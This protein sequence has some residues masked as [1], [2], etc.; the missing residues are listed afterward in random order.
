M[1]LP[2]IIYSDKIIKYTSLS[3]KTAGK[4]IYP[5][6][7]LKERYKTDPIYILRAPKVI[8]HETIHFHQHQDLIIPFLMAILYGIDYIFKLFTNNF[9]PYI[10]YHENAFEREA[11]ENQYDTEY[12]KTR[13][14]FSWFKY[15]LR[16]LK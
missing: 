3:K 9:D 4:S 5:F 10:A 15:F 7:I 12:I 13:K 1:K 14:K 11:F 2:I 8:R 16:N 6:I